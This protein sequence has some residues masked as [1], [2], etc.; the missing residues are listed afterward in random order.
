MGLQSGALLFNARDVNSTPTM[1]PLRWCSVSLPY[2]CVW[3]IRQRWLT[4]RRM[5]C[6]IALPD[7]R[8]CRMRHQIV[9]SIYA[10]L[11]S[12]RLLFVSDGS[13][14][15]SLWSQVSQQPG[16]FSLLA[17]FM[18][19]CTAVFHEIQLCTVH[20]CGL[21]IVVLLCLL[22]RTMHFMSWPS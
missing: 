6:L 15:A 10:T 11:C 21:Y 17:V 9:T 3:I 13:T 14:S 7:T 1:P 2:Y 16:P 22:W 20:L 5:L 8:L 12:F 19:V 4:C 18:H